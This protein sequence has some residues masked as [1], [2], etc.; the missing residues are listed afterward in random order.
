MKHPLVFLLVLLVMAASCSREPDYLCFE[1]RAGASISL[2]KRSSVD[3]DIQ[4]SFDKQVW[5][6]LD[7][8]CVTE[9]CRVYFRGVNPD[10]VNKNSFHSL[11]FCVSDTFACSGNIMTLIDGVGE[12]L[13][14]PCNYCF[15]R[16]FKGCP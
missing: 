15:T 6:D 7:S 13:T 1:V 4:Y 8:I 9:N 2:V 16:L 5:N 11:H 10:G 3:P 14:I 12:T